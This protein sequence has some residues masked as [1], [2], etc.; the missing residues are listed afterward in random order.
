[1]DFGIVAA[2][3]M[4]VAWAIVTFTTEAPG[5]VHILLT[6]GLFL[7]IWRIVARSRRSPGPPP[8]S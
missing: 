7:L 6:L 5:Y 1:M 3:V 8:G 2:I 4:L